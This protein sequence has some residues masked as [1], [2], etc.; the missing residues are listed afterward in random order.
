MLAPVCV[1]VRDP[2]RVPLE[3]QIPVPE[4]K[5]ALVTFQFPDFRTG[6]PAVATVF[7]RHSGGSRNDGSDP[8]IVDG[9]PKFQGPLV[10]KDADF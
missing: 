9:T 4:L 5:F 8:I 6:T 1:N 7:P 10:D 2:D 3:K